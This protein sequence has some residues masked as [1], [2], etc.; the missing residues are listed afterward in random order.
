MRLPHPIYVVG[1]V[2]G[3]VVLVEVEL[4]RVFEYGGEVHWRV[5]GGSPNV[6][7]AHP[8]ETKLTVS[9]Q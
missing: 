6:L 7:F 5:L 8:A 3:G 1:Y 9:V 2:V 4:G